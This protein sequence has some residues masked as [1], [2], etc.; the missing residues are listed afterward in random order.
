MRCITFLWRLL[1]LSYNI[2]FF[3]VGAAV[4]AGRELAN[5]PSLFAQASINMNGHVCRL[6]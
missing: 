4:E 5:E 2:C 6:M 3:V 1:T